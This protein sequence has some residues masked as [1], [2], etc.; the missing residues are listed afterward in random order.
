VTIQ[1]TSTT[2][3]ESWIAID[4]IDLVVTSNGGSP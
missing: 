2:T 1:N 3:P 4:R